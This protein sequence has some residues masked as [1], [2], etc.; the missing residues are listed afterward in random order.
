MWYIVP[1]RKQARLKK[2]IS[3]MENRVVLSDE[4]VTSNFVE[5]FTPYDSNA[6]EMSNFSE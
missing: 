5:R 3:I 2:N 1:L 4:T 6:N